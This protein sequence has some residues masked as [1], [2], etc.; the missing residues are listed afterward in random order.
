MIGRWLFFLP[1]DGQEKAKIK[2]KINQNV[3]LLT[4]HFWS[5]FF[6]PSLKSLSAYAG[7][8]KNV[9]T[10]QAEYYT[11]YG[12]M[13]SVGISIES[14]VCVTYFHAVALEAVSKL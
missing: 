9:R 11:P 13:A 14:E 2:R 6:R 7:R 1:I 4:V 12:Q 3:N 10:Y 8:T 5:P